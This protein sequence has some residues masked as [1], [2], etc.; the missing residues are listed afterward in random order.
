[1]EAHPRCWLLPFPPY[2]PNLNL[3]ERLWKFAK[4]ALVK[5]TYDEKYKAFRAQ[6]FRFLNH[7]DQYADE[8]KTLMVEKFQIRVVAQ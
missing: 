3:I 1:V 5:N 8:L 2:A 6:V 7:L 4:E